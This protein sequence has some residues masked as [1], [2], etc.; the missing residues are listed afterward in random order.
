MAKQ[1]IEDVVLI[2]LIIV[3]IGLGI[4]FFKTGDKDL[5]PILFSI[6]LASILYRF[7]GGIGNKDSF[8]LGALKLG[9][10]A[11]VLMG[12]IFFLDQVAFI[13]S[14]ENFELSV[15]PDEN[16]VPL[17]LGT[18]EVKDVVISNGTGEEKKFPGPAQ[19]LQKRKNHRYKV[20]GQKDRFFVTLSSNPADTIG[21]GEGTDLSISGL[22]AQ[23]KVSE[24]EG[25]HI[26]TLYPYKRPN[27]SVQIKEVK[28]S[29]LP[30]EIS[31]Y[32]T[33]FSIEMNGE[34]IMQN[35]EVS[36]RKAF[37]VPVR[38]GY[39]IVIIEQADHVKD[40]KKDRFSKWI[41]LKMENE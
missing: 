35:I 14:R 7:L 13:P 12:F 25:M 33:S 22:S 5:S 20:S 10:S 6:A 41:I 9:G 11:A 36:R 19:D 16:W 18:G 1:K 27:K 8:S 26:F 32:G 17:D 15:S 24:N 23:A 37:M 39:Y 30:F 4:L 31:V 34:K 40:P 29:E 21:Y 38:E 3:G 28:N 2:S